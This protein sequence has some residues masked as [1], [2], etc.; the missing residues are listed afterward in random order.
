VPSDNTASVVPVEL[1][2][3]ISDLGRSHLSIA[4]VALDSQYSHTVNQTCNGD[5]GLSLRAWIGHM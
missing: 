3:G 2:D 5:E 4:G 1:V